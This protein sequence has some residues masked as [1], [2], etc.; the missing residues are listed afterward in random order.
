MDNLEDCLECLE[1][2]S[3]GTQ[4]GEVNF[5]VFH[6]Y[7]YIHLPIKEVR[8]LVDSK[9]YTGNPKKMSQFIGM[10][11]VILRKNISQMTFI[12]EDTYFKYAGRL[13]L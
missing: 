10:P 5:K 7:L 12:S 4:L 1:H 6:I 2:Y 13:F 9:Q 11:R 3:T 8:G